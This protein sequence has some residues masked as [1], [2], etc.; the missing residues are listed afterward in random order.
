MYRYLYSALL[1][2]ESTLALANQ[3][4]NQ[5]ELA[6]NRFAEML[7]PLQQALQGLGVGAD[8]AGSIAGQSLPKGRGR[9]DAGQGRGAGAL[10]ADDAQGTPSPKP[11]GDV[12]P[13]AATPSPARA[14]A[15]QEIEDDKLPATSSVTPPTKK[16]SGS[17]NAADFKAAIEDVRDFENGLEA[18]QERKVKKRPAAA[19][20]PDSE[21]KQKPSKGSK[22]RPPLMKKGASTVFYCAG[23]VNRNEGTQKFRVFLNVG[24]RIDKS[25]SFKVIGEAKAWQRCCE[26]LEEAAKR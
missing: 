25:V 17:P 22:G 6:M 2:P 5:A 3:Q 14:E 12:S 23:K 13:N 15:P 20:G 16:P 10:A 26:M 18:R 21:A 7:M 8:A 1:R 9:A 24:D 11:V 4:Q 19:M